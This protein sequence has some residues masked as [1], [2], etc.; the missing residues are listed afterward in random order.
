MSGMSRFCAEAALGSPLCE[1][2]Y[3][4]TEAYIIL[5][6]MIT[7]DDIAV[8][9]YIQTISVKFEVPVSQQQSDVI[10]KI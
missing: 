8:I 9:L 5:I 10:R 1:M 7:D 6:L 3:S 4:F 2:H